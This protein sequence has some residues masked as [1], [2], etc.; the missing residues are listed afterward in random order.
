[1]TTMIS[2]KT[3]VIA[4]L[5]ALATPLFQGTAKAADITVRVDTGLLSG[6][7]TADSKIEVFKGIPYARP[8]IG[9]LRWKPP[10]RPAPWTGV[11]EARDAGAACMQPDGPK[12]YLYTT[13]EAHKNE[14]CLFLNVWTPAGARKAPVMVW[15]H[16]GGLITG[17]GSDPWYDGRRLAERGVVVVT[18]NYRLGIFGYFSHPELSAE[19]PHNASGNYG[20][21][22]Q[23]EALKW[24]RRNI[25][26]F[27]GDPGRVTI[28]GESAGA[29]S[30]THLM[31]SPLATGLFQ[32]GVAQSLYMPIMPE[33]RRARFGQPSAES[34]GADFGVRHGAP[35][36]ARLRAMSAEALQAAAVDTYDIYGQEPAATAAVVDGWVQ[37]AQIFETFEQG[38]EAKT[39]F[40]AGF[41]SGEMRGLDVA[42]PPFPASQ[43]AYE[44]RVRSAYGDLA[45]SYLHLY[46]S[47]SISDSS[48]AAMR[49]AYFG[50]P[51]QWF[52]RRHSGVTPATWMYYFD[53]VYPSAAERGL[54][55]FHA[56]DIAYT[57][58]T[59]GPDATLPVNYPASPSRPVDYAMSD[60]VMNYLTAFART[61]RP[62]AP[63]RPSWRPY[64]GKVQAYMTFRNGDAVPSTHL[65]PGSFELQDAYMARLR[66]ADTHWSWRN[67]GIA[68]AP[69]P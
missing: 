23:I 65:L 68:A 48:N 37:P 59:L 13:D 62:D 11:R 69:S 43:A 35:T 27:G 19:S 61:G 12:G 20:T 51:V 52:V 63:G 54:G 30:V 10:E 38:R 3:F 66:A 53:H 26:A 5:C 42:L 45:Q 57:F 39:P 46:P 18:I 9:D 29:L 6:G 15:L 24:V 28:F 47:Q 40:I 4:A 7:R 50:W 1:M 49:D 56:S 34:V 31:A 41:L 2:L 16:G 21:L 14:D 17:A 33:L 25:A 22:D 55:A 36:L 67:M 8:P 58:G 44:A 32:G 60:T 64:D